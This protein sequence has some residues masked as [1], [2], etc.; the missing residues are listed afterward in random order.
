[1]AACSTLARASDQCFRDPGLLLTA[2]RRTCD[3]IGIL[4]F[5]WELR[6]I[7]AYNAAARVI[8]IQPFINNYWLAYWLVLAYQT[9]PHDKFCTA[10]IGTSYNSAK[11]QYRKTVNNETQNRQ[12]PRTLLET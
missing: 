7:P 6:T 11:N 2:N 8:M 12:K 10:S 4:R 9:Q 3:S 5:K 1:M